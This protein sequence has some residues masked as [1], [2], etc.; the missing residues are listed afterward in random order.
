MVADKGLYSYVFVRKRWCLLLDSALTETIFWLEDDTKYLKNIN[1]VEK[2]KYYLNMHVAVKTIWQNRG[3]ATHMLSLCT[4][5]LRT[6]LPLLF[7]CMTHITSWLIFCFSCFCV[8]I[9]MLLGG[10][11]L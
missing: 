6:S 7:S 8:C 10:L 5:L 11:H 4:A 3:V 9:A 1:S 2:S